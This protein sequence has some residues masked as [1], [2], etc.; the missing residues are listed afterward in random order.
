MR[1]LNTLSLIA[2]IGYSFVASPS[3][4]AEGVTTMASNHSSK[5]SKATTSTAKGAKAKVKPGLPLETFFADLNK[6][7]M[8]LIDDFYAESFT[9]IDPVGSLSNRQ[10]M[11][12]YYSNQYQNLI[13]INFDFTSHV[14][15]TTTNGIEEHATWVMTM[16]HKSIKGGDAVVVDGATH[17]K[18]DQA[19][20][21]IYHH[22]YFDVGAFVYEHIPII[23]GLVRM[24]KGKL[25]H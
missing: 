15:K 12:A 18:R 19:G 10:G 2:L 7:T 14:I 11:R 4:R 25:S 21:V 1:M 5:S 16:K 23:G 20:F 9:F 17:L 6:D 8:F 22:D 3:L 24:V 13:S